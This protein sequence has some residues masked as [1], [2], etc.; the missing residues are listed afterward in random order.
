MR[1]RMVTLVAVLAVAFV[2]AGSAFAYAQKPEALTASTSVQLK[3]QLWTHST[4]VAF[5]TNRGA[6]ALHRRFETCGEVP[7]PKKRKLCDFSR[8]ALSWNEKKATTI[9]RTLYRTL[10]LPNDWRVAVR[11]AQRM[12]PG[13]EG[14]LLSCSA[15]EGGHGPWV[16]NG[17]APQW[18]S[19]HGSGAGGWAQFME[20]TFWRMFGAA[21]DDASRR[22]FV[23]PESAASF[24][25]PL[26][27]ALAAAWGY[28]NGRKHEW[29][30]SGCS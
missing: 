9:K 30:G 16:W 19:N 1:S 26:G 10:P 3:A 14:W 25:S 8:K 17:G 18:S 5:W 12:Y 23:V 4:K 29:M 22:G 7:W 2:A 27:Q 21:R 24:Y 15:S 6:W 13:T 28:T 11:V 20:S